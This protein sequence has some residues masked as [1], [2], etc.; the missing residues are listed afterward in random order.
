MLL[1]HQFVDL[2]VDVPDLEIAQGDFLDLAHFARDLLQ[3]LAAPFFARRDREDGGDVFGAAGAA[4]VDDAEV[5]GLRG[6]EAEE[7]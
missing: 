2:V 6:A 1:P 3:D 5:G 7:H 4:G